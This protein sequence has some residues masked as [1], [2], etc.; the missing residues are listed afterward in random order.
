MSYPSK[1]LPIP[2]PR[3]GN[4]GT[5]TPVAFSS[6]PRYLS[7]AQVLGTSLLDLYGHK[8]YNGYM[9]KIIASI[10]VLGLILSPISV[11]AATLSHSQVNALLGLLAAFG[12]EQDTIDEVGAILEPQKA[13]EPRAGGAVVQSTSMDEFKVYNLQIEDLDGEKGFYY[14]G[15]KELTG[16]TVNG[17]SVEITS[18]KQLEDDSIVVNGEKIK[19]YWMARFTAPIEDNNE[20]VLT[21][22]EENVTKTL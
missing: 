16:V 15:S 21:A 13:K 18:S 12:V 20:V 6:P 5:Q 4:G 8:G 11:S 3:T 2:W 22:G 9:N 19:G 14:A 17:A 1:N 10:A 7:P